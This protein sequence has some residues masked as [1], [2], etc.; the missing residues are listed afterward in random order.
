MGIAEKKGIK[1]YDE[2]TKIDLSS[3]QRLPKELVYIFGLLMLSIVIYT[4]KKH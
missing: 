4:Q 2:I 1:F 3:D